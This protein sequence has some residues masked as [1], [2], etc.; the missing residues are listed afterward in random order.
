MRPVLAAFSALLAIAP[1]AAQTPVPPL[2]PF[3]GVFVSP[4]QEDGS[5]WV[6]GDRYKVALAADVAFQPLL[7][8]RSP[9]DWP[10]RLQWQ[11]AAG[12]GDVAGPAA[13]TAWQ[14]GERSAERRCGACVERWDFAPER[15]QQT[16]RFEQPTSTREL[17][18]TL[19]VSTD[20][21]PQPD[22]PGV[23]FLA[24]DGR[25][26]V[27]YSDAVV[28][29]AAGARL[30]LP[31][32][33]TGGALRIVVPTTFL[34]N[35]QWPITVD[36]WLQTIVV[37][38]TA[39]DLQGAR[40]AYDETNDVWFLV[41][42]EVLSA[43]DSDIRSWRYSAGPG[44][45]VLLDTGYEENTSN[46]T[47]H[48][49]VAGVGEHALF[50]TAWFDIT[51]V[52]VGSGQVRYSRRLASSPGPSTALT[53][54]LGL[55]TNPGNR[56]FVGG[57]QTGRL[58]VVA[59]VRSTPTSA[60]VVQAR[61]LDVGGQSFSTHQF[62][63]PAVMATPPAFDLGARQGASD[64]WVM[65]WNECSGACSTTQILAK[66]LTAPQN[67]GAFTAQ[68]PIVLSSG[69]P[70]FAPRLAGS[71]GHWLAVW[72]RNTFRGAA[73]LLAQP[74]SAPGGTLGL[75]G[76][77]VDLHAGEPNSVP[78]TR[79]TAPA[80]SYDGVRYVVTY[81]EQGPS[82]TEP[83]AMTVAVDGAGNVAWHDGHVSLGLGQ[84]TGNGALDAAAST[85]V[86]LGRHFVALQRPTTNGDLL[87][88]T[89]DAYAAGTLT[90]VSNIGC[91]LPTEP[92]IGLSG[93][94]ALG[95]TFTVSLG[96][97]TGAP[98][99]LIGLP[100]IT[101]LPGCGACQQGVLLAAAVTQF[102]ASTTIVVPP[103]PAF[104]HLPIG[105]QGL[106]M[107]QAGG[108]PAAVFGVGFAL[109]DLLQVEIL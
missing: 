26:G 51:N 68:A 56:A 23:T 61:L 35:A 44:A 96:N 34:E 7:G 25:G 57:A 80:I 2:T 21:Q 24:P 43:T 106:S 102:G 85:G 38:A 65:L 87:A 101:P 28:V 3:H 30:D 31:V 62:T 98:F 18:C 83:F 4:A 91:G 66:A 48:P 42:E 52:G 45:P 59:S 107:L 16:F 12:A 105:F 50:V 60:P 15:A 64:P 97:V 11:G 82:G 71:A 20:L 1:A 109:S 84:G 49:D 14:L 33:W 104:L 79:R 54:A 93:T 36:P 5:V 88:A 81:D 75:L 78:A 76:A 74:L 46:R 95:R 89:I 67:A 37:D 10:L 9:R 27:H 63:L 90:S 32:T 6:R 13:P 86:H 69:N 94:P 73:S 47:I 99:L 72:Q 77:L 17:A 39:S 55:G 29:D 103:N 58:F 8:P 22:G 70:D 92:T 41:A 19:S 53:S 100:A 108:C 40:V